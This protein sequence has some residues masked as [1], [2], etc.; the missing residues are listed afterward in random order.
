MEEEEVTDE[1]EDMDIESMFL[2]EHNFST[3][4]G[5]PVIDSKQDTDL[6]KVRYSYQ[7]GRNASG[8]STRKFCNAM[9]G[10]T[11]VYRKEDILNMK[12]NGVN[13]F[14]NC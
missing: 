8:K 11:R 12:K 10:S 13:S 2:S 14:R 1:P 9:L 4:A 6:W 3:P 5:N 7:R